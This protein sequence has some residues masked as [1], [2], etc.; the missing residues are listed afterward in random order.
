MSGKTAS[1]TLTVMEPVRRRSARV[2]VL[3]ADDRL[4]LLRGGDPA[5]PQ[6]VIWHAPGGGVDDGEDDATAA[7]RELR[8][9]TGLSVDAVGDPVWLRSLVFSFDGVLY[10]QD[11]VFYCVRV[12]G[13]EVD[14]SGHTELERRYLS[15]HHWFCL[16]ELRT[17]PDLLAPPDLVERLTELLSD[18]PPSLPVQVQ[19]AVLP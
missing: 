1:P 14:D 7:R 18:G 6:Y 10:D 11:E 13:H 5:R 2:L 19:G 8:E 9:E 4:L 3:D 12:D 15:G 16:D 17:C